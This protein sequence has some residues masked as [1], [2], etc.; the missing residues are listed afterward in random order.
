MNETGTRDPR[1]ASPLNE[2]LMNSAARNLTRSRQKVQEF[3]SKE[4]N[5]QRRERLT[6]IFHLTKAIA[7]RFEGC[8]A[9]EVFGTA[10]YRN[11]CLP[12]FE[13]MV[14]QK[15]AGRK[16]LFMSL[17]DPIMGLDTLHFC[18]FPTIRGTSASQLQFMVPFMDQLKGIKIE[19]EVS[20][21]NEPRSLPSQPTTSGKS[22]FSSTAN[23]ENRKISKLVVRHS[24][25]KHD[26]KQAIEKVFND[27]NVPFQSLVQLIDTAEMPDEF[28]GRVNILV[29]FSLV[30][31]NVPETA[32]TPIVVDN[33]ATTDPVLVELVEPNEPAVKLS[34][35]DD[36]DFDDLVDEYNRSVRNRSINNNDDASKCNYTFPTGEP[37][38][39]VAPSK[40]DKSSPLEVAIDRILK[41]F[42]DP[43]YESQVLGPLVKADN[44]DKPFSKTADAK[45]YSDD[46]VMTP[47]QTAPSAESTP[48]PK[49]NLLEDAFLTVP[50]S[51]PLLDLSDQ[52]LH[53]AETGRE[54]RTAD[55]ATPVAT[56]KMSRMPRPNDSLISA[57]NDSVDISAVHGTP[58]VTPRMRRIPSA[59]QAIRRQQSLQQPFARMAELQSDDDLP[60][61]AVQNRT[62]PTLQSTES[63]LADRLIDYIDK[64]F[65]KLESSFTSK[66]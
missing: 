8:K 66:Q 34:D 50:M 39:D 47:V 38:N 41:R 62:A 18:W 20:I 4:E 5:G 51:K 2:Q 60:E 3:I 10:E 46:V 49:Q 33:D 54:A 44:N 9:S 32:D 22:F 45:F 42:E 16:L 31:E 13:E 35:F 61:T 65:E 12:A 57:S 15:H 43:H 59:L 6:M 19:P 17:S 26:L 21:K 64:K 24:F 11:L 27:H 14:K 40:D 37:S 30:S 29:N 56:S 53:E 48:R 28:V 25:F 52:S 58:L 63:D 23:F 36:S 55:Q 7:D 1:T